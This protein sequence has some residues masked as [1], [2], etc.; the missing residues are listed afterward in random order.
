LAATKRSQASPS[1]SAATTT[2]ADPGRS[3]TAAV[4]S[5]I[6]QF[7]G[8]QHPDDGE[9]LAARSSAGQQQRHQLILRAPSLLISAGRLRAS[10]PKNGQITKE[11]PLGLA[12]Q[13]ASASPA[14]DPS[15]VFY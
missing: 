4:L 2:S 12:R 9:L 3:S 15:R 11:P 5:S 8:H 7:F 6:F 10:E 1:I 13:I 14:S